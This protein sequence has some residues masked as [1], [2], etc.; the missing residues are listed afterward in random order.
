MPAVK[1]KQIVLASR[2][3]GEPSP[4]NFKLAESEVREP[5]EVSEAE[6]I[7]LASVP[8]PRPRP[9]RP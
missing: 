9:T 4:A 3:E 7:P 1:S 2:P 6:S 8:L 5:G